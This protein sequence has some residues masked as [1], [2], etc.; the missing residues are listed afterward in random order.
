MM[1]DDEDDDDGDN[2]DRGDAHDNR[3][4]DHEDNDGDRRWWRLSVTMIS[5]HL[6][7]KHSN[8]CWRVYANNLLC[9]RLPT[10]EWEAFR[11]IALT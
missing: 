3:D 2:D 4:V 8:G 11:A 9:G 5:G 1:D 6:S 10:S 7:F